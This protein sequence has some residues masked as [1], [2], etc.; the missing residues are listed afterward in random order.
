M[1]DFG[2]FFRS[3]RNF[4]SCKNVI[5][6]FFKK[7]ATL[8]TIFLS[9]KGTIKEYNFVLFFYLCIYVCIYV[10]MSIFFYLRFYVCHYVCTYVNNYNNDCDN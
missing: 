4:L 6:F 7:M 1:S 3:L 9:H 5:K 10:N 2:I 8:L